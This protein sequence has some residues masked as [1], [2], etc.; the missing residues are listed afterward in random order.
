VNGDGRL[1]ILEKDG[2]WDQPASLAG[3][4]VWKQHKINLGTG[5]A[6]MYA[7]D[8][9]G[10]GLN[11]I[12]TSLAA[13]GFGLAWYEQLKERDARGEIQFRQHTFMNKEPGDNKYGVKFSQLHAI[14]LVDMDGDGLKD[15]VTGKR[16][17]AHGPTGDA[18]PGA[19]AVLYW[20]KLVRGADKS[21]DF[22][23]YLIDNDSGIGTQVV[24][25][26]ANGDGLPDII[27][28]NKKGTFVHIHSK[29]SVSRE[30]WEKAQP[31]PFVRQ[32]AAR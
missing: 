10:D 9:N 7:Y 2:W 19:P 14:D 25:A 20:F 15:I 8:V 13:H 11:D 18:E 16:F 29:K 22:I 1:D 17:W 3:D 28:G 24:A 5:G 32:S 6:Q 27:V 26:D 12:I 31:R 21:V 4:P 23:P 30:E